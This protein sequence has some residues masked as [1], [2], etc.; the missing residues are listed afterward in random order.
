MT[1]FQFIVTSILTILVFGVLPTVL[2][3]KGIVQ[4]KSEEEE[5]KV[6]ERHEANLKLWNTVLEERKYFRPHYHKED[7]GEPLTTDG[8]RFPH[9]LNGGRSQ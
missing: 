6:Q 2:F 7:P 1:Q 4:R 5:V 3:I 8:I 9:D